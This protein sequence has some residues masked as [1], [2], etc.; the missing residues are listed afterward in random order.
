MPVFDV[1][2]YNIDAINVFSQ[3]PGN[4]STYNG[5]AQAEGIAIITDNQTSPND[6]VLDDDDSTNGETATAEITLGGTTTSGISVDAE[7]VWTVRDTETGQEFQVSSFEIESGPSAGFYTISEVPLIP[8]RDYEIVSFDDV[9]DVDDGDDVFTYADFSDGIVEGTDGDDVIDTDYTGDPHGDQI[10][11]ND[12]PNT[13]APVEESLN[14][15]DFGDE[16]DLSGGVTQNTGNINVSVSYSDASPTPNGDEF[17]AESNTQV[18]VDTG[19]P[20]DSSS[21]AYLFADGG[22]DNSIVTMDFDA[23][24]GSGFEDEVE[25]V[26]FRINDIDGVI[27][28]NNNFQDILTITAFD[29]DGNPVPVNITISGNDSVDGNT[30]TA[31]ID[32]DN[33]SQA[34]GSA[35]IE[36]AGPVSRI[37]IEYDNGGDTQQG[38]NISDVHFDAVPIGSND[39]VVDAGDGN[40]LVEAGEG[41]DQVLGGSGRDT[42]D[43]GDGDDTL[44]GGTGRDTLIGGSGADVLIGGGGADV[45]DGGTGDDSLSGGNG[46]DTLTGGAGADTMDGGAGNDVFNVGSGDSATGGDGD[47]TFTIDPAELNGGTIFIGGGEGAETLGDTLDFNGQ[48]DLGSIVYT[49]T[50]DAAGGLSGTATLLDGTV[51]TFE[52]IETIICFA[53]GTSILT[54][55]G[56]RNVQDLKVGDLVVTRDNGVQAIRWTGSRTLFAQGKMA[57]IEFAPGSIMN[58]DRTLRV[59]PQHRMLISNY[60]A[61]L[62]FGED[63]VLVAAKHLVNGRDIVRIAPQLVTYHHILFDQHEVIFSNGAQTESY[64]PGQYS[65]GGIDPK[66]RE[67]LFSLFPDLKAGTKAYGPSARMTV[68]GTQSHMLT[69]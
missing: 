36:I 28:G 53:Q 56:L 7:E 33:A 21:S 37:V 13:N 43:G 26:Q 35:L 62:Y 12:N 57:P 17:S 8:G 47:D 34:D 9:P 10:D 61:Q 16:A 69:E 14:W 2:F 46:G 41:E 52:N 58:N 42:L 22:A 38:V 59:S 67:E 64:N 66:A 23:V 18:Y 3:T 40:D 55:H 1:R 45:L 44:D 25:N 27:N 49:N 48:L 31:L 50:D 15:Q 32:G 60:R 4:T 63:E 54:P 39:D 20:F 11:N 65:L 6:Q 51:V 30:I 68:R 19:E 29:A 24:A 5:P